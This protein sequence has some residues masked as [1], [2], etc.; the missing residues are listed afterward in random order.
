MA[1]SGVSPTVDARGHRPPLR[2]GPGHGLPRRPPRAGRPAVDPCRSDRRFEALAEIIVY[3]Q[4][5]GRA[6]A[7]IHGRF[8]TALGGIVTPGTVLAAPDQ[9]AG[10]EPA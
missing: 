8:V 10:L 5:A 1:S 7:T 2:P 4:L 3:Q 6:A 9:T